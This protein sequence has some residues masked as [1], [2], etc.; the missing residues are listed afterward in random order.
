MS[1]AA[2][3]PPSASSALRSGLL[4]LSAGIGAWCAAPLIGHP[5]YA[6][7]ILVIGFLGA[8]VV[9]A[10]GLR[11]CRRA[12]MIARFGESVRGPLGVRSV[13]DLQLCSTR[14]TQGWPG[15]P[16][17]V[18]LHYP[19]VVE[20]GGPRW[21]SEVTAAAAATFGARYTTRRNDRRRGRLVL[22]IDTSLPAESSSES[23]AAERARRVIEDLIGPTTK[24]ESLEFDDDAQV[25][26]LDVTYAAGARLVASGYRARIERTVS[27]MLPGRWRGI[28]DMEGDRVRFEVRPTL[29]DSI[30]IEPLEPPKDD[31]LSNYD[32]V[33]IPLG[34][35]EDGHEIVWRPAISPQFLITGGTGSGKTSSTHAVLTRIAQYGWPIWVVDGKAVEFLGFR[36]WPNV[37][38]VASTVPDQV[39]VIHRAW[40]LM[41]RRY[42]LITSGAARADDFEPLIVFLDEFADFRGNLLSW[43]SQVKVKGDPTKPLTLAEVASLARKARTARVHIVAA[44]QRPDAE[45]LGGEMRDN[46]T[47]RLSVGRLSPQGAMMM[48][49]NPTIGVSLPRG[50][51]GRAI[52]MNAAGIPVEMQCYRTPDPAKVPPGSAEAAILD[53][54]RPPESRQERLV[55]VPVDPDVDLDSGDPSDPTFSDYICADWARAAERP[56]LDPLQRSGTPGSASSGRELASPMAMLGLTGQAPRRP[57][58]ELIA[59][60]IETSAIAPAAD[61]MSPDLPPADDMAGEG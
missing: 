45:F 38:L 22:K 24:I 17:I 30:W 11:R 1:S 57:R 19:P 29:P 44:T 42:E 61:G 55:I 21:A 16:R 2:V 59:T 33:K 58:L 50:K 10:S 18:K 56:D 7:P 40:E 15:A 27:T 13:Q 14:W 31:P 48:W 25:L 51:R 54:L 39:A 6:I 26:A 34:V 36:D 60:R 3:A 49:E 5:G 28:W 47:M 35:D 53:C 43:Y 4:T 20:A 41:E 8:A 46:F 9:I 32:Q 12:E 37:Q 23:P 52:A